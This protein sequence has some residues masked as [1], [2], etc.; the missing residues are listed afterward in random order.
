MLL[1][2]G[3]NQKSATVAHRERLALRPEEL[4]GLIRSSAALGGVDE[5]VLVSTCYRVELYAATSCPSAAATAL[6]NALQARAGIDLPLFELHGDEALR[7]LFRVAASLES[8]VLGEP[9]ILG[10]V[11]DAHRRALQAGTAGKELGAVLDRVYAVAKRVRTETGVGRTGVSWGSAA[12][13]L[14]R[15]VLGELS[16]REVLVVGAGEIARLS[17]QHLGSLG[18]KLTVV[19]RT[20]VAAQALAAEVGGR[21]CELERLDE[22][23]LRADV[24]VSAAPAAP[25]AFSPDALAALMKRRRGRDLVAVDLAVPRAIP[26]ESGAIDGVFLCDVDDLAKLTERARSERSQAVCDAEA[27][28]AEEL[29]HASRE[30]AQRRAAPVIR[31][32][33]EQ[34]SEIA[35]GE[36]NRTLR[37]LGATD[38]EVE[39]RL[40]AMA[41]AL[42]AKLL[43]APSARL[44]E[45][46]CQPGDGDR[47]VG[48]ALRIFDVAP[49]LA[50]SAAR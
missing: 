15:K 39:T 22:E 5:L 3:L 33:R 30:E 50:R 32:I 6:R 8:A 27:I 14:A 12:A 40:H 20:F 19:N 7:H 42:V 25:A 1:A 36:V 37:R 13:T 35:R 21:A 49:E 44:R 43:H 24:V 28:I 29:A 11:K 10:Q 4:E 34:A 45:A 46:S 47:L 9:Q 48:A 17:A 18:A 38:P 16:G 41:N 2:V 31:A 26:A 23:L